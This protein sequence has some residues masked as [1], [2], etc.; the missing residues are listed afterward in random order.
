MKW[1]RW[2]TES[3]TSFSSIRLKTAGSVRIR[4]KRQSKYKNHFV[5]QMVRPTV[6]K[7]ATNNKLY[8]NVELNEDWETQWETIA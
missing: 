8:K 1:S 5:Y 7:N 2:Y 6:I 3:A 4:L